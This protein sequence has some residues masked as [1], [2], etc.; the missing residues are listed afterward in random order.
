V[1]GM[2][3]ISHRLDA[4]EARM[5]KVEHGITGLQQTQAG[6][7]RNLDRINDRLGISPPQ[8]LENNQ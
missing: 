5:A 6:A 1:T 4:L 2:T 3:T 8:P 7:V